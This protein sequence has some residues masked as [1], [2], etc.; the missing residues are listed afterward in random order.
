VPEPYQVERWV[1]EAGEAKA[2]KALLQLERL[3]ERKDTR[4]RDAQRQVG[5]AFEGPMAL[6]AWLREWEK[7]LRAALGKP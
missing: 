7:A 5:R 1:R 3:L 6:D 2:R 4:L